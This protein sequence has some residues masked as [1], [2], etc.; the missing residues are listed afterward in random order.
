MVHKTI[1]GFCLLG[2][3]L[4]LQAA[5]HRITGPYSH[6]NLSIYLIHGGAKPAV[7]G[8]LTLQEALEQ[9]KVVVYETGQV[10]QL[11]IENQS[12]VEVFIQAG[13]IV[14]GGK[15]DRV[16]S[17]D[18]VLPANSGRVPIASF[19]VEQGRWTRRGAESPA[20]FSA[21]SAALPSKSLKLAVREEKSQSRVW[22]SVAVMQDK[23]KPMAGAPPETSSMQLTLENRAV[24]RTTG[25]YV[26]KL[27]G[28]VNGKPDVIGYAYAINGKMNS[29]DVYGSPDLFRKM[30][31]K[32]LEASAAEA[33]SERQEGKSFTP[34]TL[35]SVKNALESAE[36]A[37]EASREKAGRLTVTKRDSGGVLLYEARDQERGGEWIHKSYVVK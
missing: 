31:R 5:D 18:L 15:Q 17:T 28:I 33:A 21:S 12:S 3:G 32:M 26:E 23:L 10:N 27:A 20:Q 4:A 36:Q 2:F 7:T 8:L 29:A 30:W 6:D 11:A 14:K 22:N 35:S 37:R 13:D 16:L 24:A 9:R 1:R 34:P 19:C 25:A